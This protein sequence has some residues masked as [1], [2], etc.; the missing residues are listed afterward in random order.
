MRRIFVLLLGTSFLTACASS[1]GVKADDLTAVSGGDK[2]A[3]LASY[4]G[5]TYCLALHLNYMNLDTKNIVTAKLNPKWMQGPKSAQRK[6]AVVPVEPGRY[7]FAGG[8]C[9]IQTGAKPVTQNFRSLHQWFEPFEVKAGEAVYPGTLVTQRVSY[10]VDGVL[11]LPEFISRAP[12]D[13][14]LVY[15][16]E[17]RN[18][19]VQTRL[20]EDAPSLS[21]QYVTKMAPVRLSRDTVKQILSDAYKFEGKKKAPDGRVA[22]SKARSAFAKYVVT[23]DYKPNP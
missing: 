23:G 21:S 16:L 20:S 1:S 12:R 14:Y 6:V 11:N 19:Q 5:E 7:K 10:K 4:G 17:D 18:D 22:S 15:G 8:G 9:Q 3:I 13:T 2:A